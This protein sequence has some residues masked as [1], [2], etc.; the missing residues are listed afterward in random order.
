MRR[1]LV[2][3]T[4]LDLR[5]ARAVRSAATPRLE[6]FCRFVTLAADEHLALPLGVLLWL[7]SRN[8]DAAR[9]RQAGGLLASLVA[10]TLLPHLWKGL[11]AQKRPD[12]RMVHGDRNGVPRSGDPYGAFPSGHAMHVGAIVSSASRA[13]P[14][15]APGIWVLGGLIAGT[16]IALLAHWASDVLL[17]WAI[18]WSL[19]RLI[20]RALFRSRR[21]GSDP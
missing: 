18:G 4:D 7:A 15:A 1:V 21:S 8:V 20:W 5:I 12:R 10:T 13:F 9:R 6:R 16:R 14:A 11:F 17:G 3:P 19:D 2:P